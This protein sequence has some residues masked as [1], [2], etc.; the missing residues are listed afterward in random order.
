MTEPTRKLA[1]MPDGAMSYLDW[2]TQAH[3]G[4]A[5]HFA[6]ATGFNAQTYRGLLEPLAGRFHVMAGDARGHGHSALGTAPGLAAGWTIFRD[7]LLGFLDDI[8]GKPVILA[9]HS[10][11]AIVSLLVAVANPQIVRGL[12]LVEP[13]LVPAMA[14]RIGR[15][16]AALHIRRDEMS[17]VDRAAKRRDMFPSIDDAFAAYRGRGAFRTWP[18]ETIRD[19]L[20]GGMALDTKTGNAHLTCTPKWEAETFRGTPLGAARLARHIKCPVTLIHGVN[21]TAP[22]SEVQRFLHGHP[23]TRVVKVEGASHF[24]PMERPE[25]VRDEINL[26]ADH[27][28]PHV[29]AVQ[30]A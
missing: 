28:R 25:I 4:P 24:L 11:G 30:A 16:L 10:M 23:A 22:D 27:L 5:L 26:I 18:D 8:G 20:E 13:V 19:Y 21:G 7:D 12:V 2:A 14:S 29:A 17:L 15:V 3:H 6:H 9:G 1:P